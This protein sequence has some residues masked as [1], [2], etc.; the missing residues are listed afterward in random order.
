MARA[1]RAMQRAAW[2][3]VDPRGVG[4]LGGRR[5]GRLGDRLA[6]GRA[7]SGEVVANR[8]PCIMLRLPR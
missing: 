3:R 8:R 2:G 7:R 6:R 1:T 4:D 5:G